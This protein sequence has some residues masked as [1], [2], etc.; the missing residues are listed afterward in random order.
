[1]S[2]GSQILFL[3]A[4]QRFLELIAFQVPVPVPVPVLMPWWRLVLLM[5]KEEDGGNRRVNAVAD[6]SAPVHRFQICYRKEQDLRSVRVS[7]LAI[8]TARA[9]ADS[10]EWVA[11]KQ[12]RNTRILI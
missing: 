11:A 3:Q 5:L 2:L 1:M 10:I 7:S 12:S 8:M 9:S 6:F 4:L